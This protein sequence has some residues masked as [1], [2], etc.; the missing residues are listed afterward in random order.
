MAP[1]E[2]GNILWVK[3]ELTAPFSM[4]DM[5]PITFYLGLKVQCNRKNWKIK[6]FQLAYIDKV[7]NWFYFEKANKVVIPMKESTIF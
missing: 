4:V 1:K 6:L 2:N 7:L 5:G 3:T